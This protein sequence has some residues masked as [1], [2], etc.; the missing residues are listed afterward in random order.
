MPARVRAPVAVRIGAGDALEDAAEP[1][2]VAAAAAAR[3]LLDRETRALEQQAA[4]L[5]DAALGD[6]AHDRAA[7]HLAVEPA[8]VIGIA[9]EAP[10]DAR[11]AD[12][13]VEA[14]RDLGLGA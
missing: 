12:R 4:R 1:R 14:A 9:A 10:R 13:Q 3:D 7:V 11:G 2:L 5:D 6:R 8:E